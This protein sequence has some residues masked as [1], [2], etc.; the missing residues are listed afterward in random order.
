MAK[1]PSDIK[2]LARAHTET[3]LRVLAGIMNERDAPHMARVT[4]SNSLLDRGWGKAPVA[5][6]GTNDL[7]AIALQAIQRTIVDPKIVD[8]TPVKVIDKP[9]R[10]NKSL[11]QSPTESKT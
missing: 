4:A 2:S 7:P 9:K 3:A 5:I 8:V 6:G 1:T 11:T 10:A